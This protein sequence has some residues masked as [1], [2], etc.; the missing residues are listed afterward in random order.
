[1][2]GVNVYGV[3]Q[4]GGAMVSGYKFLTFRLHL[5]QASSELA[6]STVAS[7]VL[8]IDCCFHFNSICDITAAMSSW[9]LNSGCFSLKL[10]IITQDYTGNR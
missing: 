8:D 4:A 2:A 10:H 5:W 1:M 3:F 6:A 9:C 7:E